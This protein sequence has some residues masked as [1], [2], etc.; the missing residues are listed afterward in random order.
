MA[1]PPPP[2]RCES[3]PAEINGSVRIVG[4]PDITRQWRLSTRAS[5]YNAS[6][7]RV[8]RPLRVETSQVGRRADWTFPVVF[9][10]SHTLLV[11]TIFTHFGAFSS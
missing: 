2:L 9:S 1:R 5:D 4:Q 7:M 10:Q 6:R 3:S 11:I 8:I